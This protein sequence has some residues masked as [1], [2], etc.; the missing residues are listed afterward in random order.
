MSTR[1]SDPNENENKENDKKIAPETQSRS[2]RSRSTPY[3]YGYSVMRQLVRV[4]QLDFVDLI[5]IGVGTVLCNAYMLITLFRF[6]LN[7]EDYSHA[8]LVPVIAAAAAW[9]VIANAEK[10]KKPKVVGQFWGFPVLTF[11]LLLQFA[12]MWYEIG[13]VAG[14]VVSEYVTS[15][16]LVI[17]IWGLFICFFGFGALKMFWFPLL[18]LIFL[19]PGLPGPP[20]VWLKNALRN[21]VTVWSSRTLEL[22]GYSVLVE[23]NVITIPGVVL[24]VADACSGIRSLWAML[25]VAPAIAWFLRLRPFLISLFIPLGIFLAIFQ[26]IIRVVATA[27]LCD[28]F[29]MSWA[30]GTKHD[31][32]GGLSFFIVS[33]IMVIL[34]RILA[35]PPQGKKDMYGDYGTYGVYGHYGSGSYGSYGAYHSANDPEEDDEKAPQMEAE[36][37]RELFFS[38][39]AKVRTGVFVCLLL[40]GLGQLAIFQRYAVRSRVQYMI[41]QNRDPLDAFPGEVGPFRRIY[42]GELPEDA[43][44]ILRPSESYVA[45]YSS[46]DDRLINVIINFWE[47]VI[48]FHG[49]SWSFPHSPDVCFRE[50]GWVLAETPE[51]PDHLDNPNEVVFSR[52]YKNE[53]LGTTQMVLYWY[54]RDQISMMMNEQID[55]NVTHGNFHSYLGRLSHVARSW[56][57][58]KEYSRFQ[59]SVGIYVQEQRSVEDTIELA[60]EFAK[61]LREKTSQFGLRPL[62]EM[63]LDG[64]GMDEALVA[65][66]EAND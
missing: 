60:Q 12:A 33:M 3:E 63:D 8:I 61:H 56:K 36:D 17:T 35:P 48:G 53:I 42:W 9:K 26:N 1:S 55:E 66:L 19:I 11:G 41:S 38:R 43:L 58:P 15:V 62:Q 47:P 34:S 59:Y 4:P 32:V 40:M 30:S 18:Y 46:E 24:G 5:W 16:G 21:T 10:D 25:A 27:L 64:M 20:E 50:A 44:R 51:L 52:L 37:Q 57:Y 14:G 39:I 28:W 54:N 23:G 13:L 49:N 6:Y 65:E 7:M 29:D 22:F 45:W 2:R 31:I